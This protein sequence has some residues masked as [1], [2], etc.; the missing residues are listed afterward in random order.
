MKRLLV[1]FCVVDCAVVHS[2]PVL[3]AVGLVCHHAGDGSRVWSYQVSRSGQD[4]PRGN[5]MLHVHQATGTSSVVTTNSANPPS[6]I[7]IAIYQ[8]GS[9]APSDSTITT[10]FRSYGLTTIPGSSIRGTVT[11][12][13]LTLNNELWVAMVVKNSGSFVQSLVL[14]VCLHYNS[15]WLCKSRSRVPSYRHSCTLCSEK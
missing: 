15:H 13:A 6:L 5:K 10:I 7:I 8:Q 4:E 11:G 2:G 3:L 12:V 14:K 1:L 9:A